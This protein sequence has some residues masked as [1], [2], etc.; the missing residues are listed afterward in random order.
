MV[1][2]GKPK[3]TEKHGKTWGIEAISDDHYWVWRGQDWEMREQFEELG[4]EEVLRD[5]VDELWRENQR[6]RIALRQC[7]GAG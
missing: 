1:S 2:V 4:E 6:L 5:R 3:R 7:A